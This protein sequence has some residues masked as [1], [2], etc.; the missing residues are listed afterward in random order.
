MFTGPD[1]VSGAQLGIRVSG[2]RVGEG[3]EKDE[4]L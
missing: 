1:V 3:R 2:M 4:G